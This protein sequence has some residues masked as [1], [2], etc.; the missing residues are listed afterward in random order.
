MDGYFNVLLNHLSKANKL[1]SSAIAF[2][3]LSPYTKGNNYKE[4][5]L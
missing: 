2:F 5:L 4:V 1:K 3:V